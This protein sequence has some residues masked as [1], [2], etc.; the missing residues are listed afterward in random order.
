MPQ[1]E[2]KGE[3]YVYDVSA[4]ELVRVMARHFP[5]G[6]TSG[7]LKEQFGK[8]TGLKKQT[9][10][11][12]LEIAKAKQRIVGGGGKK[13]QRY[14]LNPNGCWQEALVE[15]SVGRTERVGPTSNQSI[16]PITEQC[17]TDSHLALMS[18]ALQHIDQKKR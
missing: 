7:K 14:C 11:N 15:F 3:A 4:R 10:Y 17:W 16:G 8:D 18:E 13:G 2:S 1:P 12:A 9:Y 6:T 5:Y